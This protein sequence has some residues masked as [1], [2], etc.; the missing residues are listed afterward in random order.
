MYV[1]QSATGSVYCLGTASYPFATIE[2]NINGNGIVYCGTFISCWYTTINN[3]QTLYV[4]GVRGATGAYGISEA[5]V[6]S[7]GVGN[8]NL[9]IGSSNSINRGGAT[10]N[11][12]RG[13]FCK[14]YCQTCSSAM[15]IEL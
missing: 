8:M 5:T 10:I 9:Y 13:D 11:C 3:V 2:G 6:N 14:V 1:R 12:E 7:S 15:T 4:G